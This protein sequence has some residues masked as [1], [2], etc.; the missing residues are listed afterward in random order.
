ML[1]LMPR[2][3]ALVIALAAATAI[4]G[5]LLPWRSCR[6]PTAPPPLSLAVPARPLPACTRRGPVVLPAASPSEQRAIADAFRRRNGPG[7]HADDSQLGS[8]GAIVDPISRTVR[9]SD[10]TTETAVARLASAD[11]RARAT[12]FVRRNADL[13]GIWPEEIDLLTIMVFPEPDG[14]WSTDF[15]LTRPRPGYEAFPSVRRALTVRV[16]TSADGARQSLR[17]GSTLPR[18]ELCTTPLLRPDDPAIRRSVLSHEFFLVGA[19]GGPMSIG[20][21]GD[22]D[23]PGAPELIIDVVGTPE[24][25]TLTLAYRQIVMRGALALYVAVDADTGRFLREQP[26]WVTETCATAAPEASR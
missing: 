15:T 12:D 6:P 1:A 5:S 4:A 11:A 10:T 18:F 19:D 26:C 16:V 7:W 23:L 14:A 20:R 24:A 8:V 2:Q 9:F 3:R 25:T 21:P 13:L 22:T 17:S